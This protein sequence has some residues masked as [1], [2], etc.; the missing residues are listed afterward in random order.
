MFAYV[1]LIVLAYFL[2]TAL[3][4]SGERIALGAPPLFGKIEP[5]I[6]F[7]IV[8][9][10]LF[11]AAVVVWGH[12]VASSVSWK[13]LLWVSFGGAAIW[14]VALA[15]ADGFQALTAP[16]SNPLDAYAFLPQAGSLTDFLASFIGRIQSFPIHVQ[17]HPP[18]LVVLLSAFKAAG[19]ATPGAVAAL[20]IAGGAAVVPA[21]L[22]SARSVSGEELAR[23]AAPWLVLAPFAVWIATSADALYAGVAA[24]GVALMISA[25]PDRRFKVFCG[26]LLFGCGLFLTYGAAALAIVPVGV[27]IAR[28]NLKPLLY[29]CGGVSVVAL[30]FALFGFWWFEG[31]MATRA[32]Y[33]DG[34]GGLRPYWYFLIANLAALAI[35]CGPAAVRGMIRPDI[36]VDGGRLLFASALVAV[37]A[38]NLSGLSKGEVERI[39]LLFTPWLVL[40]AAWIGPQLR[41]RW[42]LGAS[43]ATA[44]AVQVLVLSPW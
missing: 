42:W 6:S 20:Y 32:Q 7:R 9:A 15:A 24:W 8:P 35:A 31:L 5:R 23:A 25:D 41:R 44:I 10:L 12:R 17:G 1:G 21:V 37:A 16:V 2:G 19:M 14:A 26:G 38:A 39:W 36:P 13:R 4:G 43:A 11:A 40:A 27:A 3:A 30:L 28:G 22:V 29:A 33:Y 18:G 34:I